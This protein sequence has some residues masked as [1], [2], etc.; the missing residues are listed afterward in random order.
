M[1]RNKNVLYLFNLSMDLDNPVLATTNL[2]VN[3]FAKKFE[4]VYVYS[5]HVGRFDVAKNVRVTELGG[6][7]LRSRIIAI[8]RILV[9]SVSILTNYRRSV[10][11]H[12]QS[13]FTSV[14]PGILLR[15]VGIKQGLWYSHSSKPISLILGS[16]ISNCLFSSSP[17]SLPLKSKKANFFGHG[18]DTSRAES[19]FKRSINQRSGILYL[20][21]I[22]PIK[23][24]EECLNA[25]ADNE[26]NQT[27]FVAIGPTN[28]NKEYLH[29]LEK[30]ATARNICFERENPINHELVFEKMSRFSMFFSGMKNS[31][32][33]SCLEAAATGCFVITTDTASADLSGMSYFWE[34]VNGEAGLPE[35]GQ[36]I[37][38]I[39][40]IDPQLLDKYRS[41]VSAKAIELNSASKLICTISIK[42]KE[43]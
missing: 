6:G 33:K 30:I 21:R 37:R 36:Q 34:K 10:V 5:T 18:I 27:N 26:F 32:D 31:V 29:K 12:H 41:D 13:P 22:S 11:F 35:L 7:T 40:S 28:N 8:F 19:I 15:V 4:L 14:F 39:N 24:L 16:K 25:L 2:W 1:I 38:I 20:G 9:A 17:A 23:K 43:A 3:E 42:L